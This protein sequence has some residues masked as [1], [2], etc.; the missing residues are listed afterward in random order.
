MLNLNRETDIEILRKAALLLEI[1]NKRLI[2]K[3]LQ[4]QKEVQQASGKGVEAIQQ[5]L[6]LLEEELQLAHQKIFGD[7][8]E[9]TKKNN[10]A[11]TKNTKKQKGHGPTQQLNLEKVEVEYELDEADKVCPKCGGSLEEMEGQLETSEEIDVIERKF[12]IKVHKRKKYR[13]RCQSCIETAP[14]PVKLVS[15]GRYS[16]GFAIEVAVS[17]YADHLPL[18][19]Q[20]K[21]FAREGLKVTFQTLWDQINALGYAVEVIPERIRK[22]MIETKHILGAIEDSFLCR[23]HSSGSYGIWGETPSNKVS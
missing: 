4:L 8:S 5:Q 13:C 12:V 6:A 1:E 19:R 21:I 15:S 11:S 9:K 20:C 2:K 14:G 22:Y 23:G 16:L 7:S 10:S 18:E 3:N 17:K